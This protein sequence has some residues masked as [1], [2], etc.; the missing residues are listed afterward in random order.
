MV[1]ELITGLGLF[2][3]MLD[4]AKGLKDMNDAAVRNA[5]VIELQ[6]K[7]LSAR[8]QQAALLERIS[9]LEEG[10]ARFETWEAEKQRYE[11]KKL[12]PGVL[13][14]VVKE[15][16][17][18]SEPEHYLCANCYERGKKRFLH[19]GGV[20]EGI[21]RLKCHECNTELIVGEPAP[22]HFGNWRGAP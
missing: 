11:L 22:G 18:G 7:I 5:A 13:V 4:M 9:E 20:S 10:V 8:E 3:S 16:V 15:A 6:E 21:E 14:Y 1:S 17:R 2:K 19:S 12:H